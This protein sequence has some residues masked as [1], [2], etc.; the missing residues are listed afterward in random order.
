MP[1]FGVFWLVFFHIRTE[2][3][4]VFSPNAGKYRSE[5]LR[6]QTLFTQSQY[7][8]S[9]KH[10]RLVFGFFKKI[11]IEIYEIDYVMENFT[12]RLSL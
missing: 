12:F 5:K 1:V 10:A 7:P 4:G 2:L 9:K 6:I 11:F 3:I 8:N